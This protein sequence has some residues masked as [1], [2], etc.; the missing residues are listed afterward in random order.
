MVMIGCT[1]PSVQ[2]IP[3]PTD[4]RTTAPVAMSTPAASVA[5]GRPRYVS[6]PRSPEGFWTPAGAI[7]AQHLLLVLVPKAESAQ[8]RLRVS[9]RLAT[10]DVVSGTLRNLLTLPP[11]QQASSLRAWQQT[12]AWVESRAVDLSG[13]GWRLHLTD[14]TSG[15]DSVI[16]SDSGFRPFDPANFG[17]AP[18]A[19]PGPA[20]LLYTTLVTT[21]TGAAW[22]LRLRA[23]SG[24]RTLRTLQDG[25]KERFVEV[26]Q[27]A[28][29]ATW[30][31]A[32]RSADGT[33]EALRAAALD[34][35]AP[36]VRTKPI[37]G[38]AY[39]LSPGDAD[40]FIGSTAG[41]LLLDRG[42]S[43]GPT[44]VGFDAALVEQVARV[45]GG[46]LARTPAGEALFAF[47]PQT[48]ATVQVSRNVTL[49]PIQGEGW[50]FWYERDP[51]GGEGR[52][53]LIAGP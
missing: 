48:R 5:I 32:V 39:D 25:T 27:D 9:A 41:L 3:S 18:R 22:E 51:A 40:I 26:R 29:G 17:Y 28:I 8:D 12:V 30:L 13:V 49:G 31:E 38:R 52:V 46:L 44:L 11:G 20:G 53:G 37:P 43:A 42:M 35:N 34:W 14:A 23:D 36:L 45:P 1:A 7:G 6:L 4:V 24:E 2:P 15:R 16:M 50:A 33:T 21:P 47:D 10:F 19:A